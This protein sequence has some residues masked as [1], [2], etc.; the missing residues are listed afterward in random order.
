MSDIV[1][2]RIFVDGEKGITA[3]KMNQ[4]I[5]QAVIQPEF[6][7]GKP[8][9][10]TLDSTDQL[11]EL[12]SSGAYARINGQQL[13]DSVSGQIPVA[14][15]TQNG[16][17]R[18]VSG[19]TTDYVDGTNTCKPLGSVISSVSLRRYNAIGN[20][21]FEIDQV[22]GNVA[23]NYTAGGQVCDR[24]IINK[25]GTMVFGAYSNPNINL[26]LPGSTFYFSRSALTMQLNTPQASLGVNDHCELLQ[27]VE[28]SAMREML[29]G[30]TSLSLLVQASVPV[31]FAV[32][33]ADNGAAHS[34]VKLCSVTTANVPTLFSFPNLP[35][36]AAG[37]GWNATPGFVGYIIRIALCA[38]ANYIGAADTWQNTNALGAAGMSNFA[39]N[40]AGAV[41]HIQV[42]QHESG[43]LC[44]TPFFDKSSSDNLDECLRYYQKTYQ[45]LTPPG[46]A[47]ASAGI[48]TMYG[49]AAGTAIGPVSFHKPM[50]K[51]PAMMAYNFATGT[52]NS[53]RD[54]GGN[55][56]TP[57]TFGNVGD[58]GFATLGITGLAANTFAFVHYTAITGW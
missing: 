56:L 23:V 38:G 51:I 39:A 50:A 52:A 6:Y 44:T 54:S 34:L 33:L 20:G 27:Y 9:S 17:L 22:R 32:S 5:S 31:T 43:P 7:S 12:K 11:L 13:I 15:A 19:L 25:T 48:R 3:T 8:T 1:T 4:I 16:M 26:A 35:V 24:W 53:I 36:W 37:G 18:K 57:V 47:S 28:G 10:S 21:N 58:S 55:D 29:G 45:Y 41:F 46:T 40:S 49:V 14:D 42:V 30:P 2:S